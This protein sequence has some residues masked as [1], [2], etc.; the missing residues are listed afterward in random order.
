MIRLVGRLR[1]SWSPLIEVF[2]PVSPL[3]VLYYLILPS[4]LMDIF[5]SFC[6]PFFGFYHL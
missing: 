2:L 6:T 4:E 1:V 5:I 3:F